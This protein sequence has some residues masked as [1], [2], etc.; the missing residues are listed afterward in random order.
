MSVC[1][2]THMGSCNHMCIGL[3][4]VCVFKGC[5]GFEE[6]ASQ[7]FVCGAAPQEADSAEELVL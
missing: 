3:V 5:A 7:N 1:V 2:S 4:S 6:A